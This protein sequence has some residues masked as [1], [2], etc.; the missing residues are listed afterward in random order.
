MARTINEIIVHCTA[1]KI[2]RE[3]S[4]DE[5]R[6]WHKAKGWADVGYH[7][8]VHLDGS[9]SV[10]RPI[11]KMGAHCEGHNQHSVGVVYVGGLGLNGKACDTRTEAQKMAL[12]VLVA[13]LKKVYNIT[14]VSGHRDY[15]KA[16][17][18]PCFDAKNEYGDE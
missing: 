18:C 3:V 5:L 16:K 4:V 6:R 11:D 8:V 1:T 12:R 7:F 17:A 15:N 14:K 10:G 9:I 13:G 2:G